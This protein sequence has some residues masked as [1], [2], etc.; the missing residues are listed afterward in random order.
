MTAIEPAALSPHAPDWPHCGQGA[1]PAAASVGCCGRQ[2][3]PYAECLAHLSDANR[4]AYLTSLQPGADV[5]HRGTTFTE[6]LLSQLLT[7][8]RDPATEWPC[9]GHAQFGEAKFSG[10]ARFDQVKI[11]GDAGFDRVEIRHT[12]G[13]NRAVIDG[14]AH[15]NRAKIGAHALFDR[16][17]IGGHA[18]F[19]LAEI[20]LT[21]EF[22]RA[23][24]SGNTRLDRVK[25]GGDTKFD[26]VQIGGFVNFED[27]EIGGSIRFDRAKIRSTAE[28]DRIKI[29]GSARFSAAEIGA[30][31]RFNGAEIGDTA[32]FDHV[33]ID[34]D[35]GF[36]GMNVRGHAMFRQAKIGRTAG[37]SRVK[38]DG[39]AEYDKV[40]IGGRALFSRTEIGGH[41]IF[42]RAEIGRTAHFGRVKIR[43]DAKFDGMNIR[44]DANFRTAVF[45]QA[46]AIGPL[47]CTGTLD[48]S[49]TAFGTAVTIEAATSALH[50]RRTR[51]A[52]T[53]AL[54]LRYAAVDLSDAVVEYPLSIAAYSRPFIVDGA[55]MPEAGLTATS[56][57]ARS[58]RG[59][60]A[61]HLV[62]T[63]V[64][65]S[66]CLFAGTIHL[67]QL[68]LEG[69]CSL[70]AVPSALRWRSWWVRWT[71]RRT[72]AEEQHWRAS[73]RSTAD[74]WTPAP[75]GVEAL[76]PASLAPVYRQLRKAFEDGKDEPGAADFYYGE[77]EMRRHDRDT[78]RA[79]RGLLTGYWALSGY[80]LRASR[81]LGWLV[82]AMTATVLVMMLWG[83]P[84]GDPQPESAGT[85]TGHRISLT[86]D[87]PDPVNPDTPLAQRMT[88][89]RFEKALRVVIN[90]VVF[91]S[92]GQ[93]LTTFGTYAEMVSR[94]TEPVLLGLAVLAVRSRVKR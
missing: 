14:D 27:A 90:S 79:E 32:G 48:L 68:R 4:S 44:G 28:F 52:S 86:T 2:V 6:E 91:R 46:A 5:D 83:L 15:F 55:E 45:E 54:R 12:A 18:S 89:Q 20:G 17:V 87:T 59:V 61:A 51:W 62:L 26:R 50:C 67:D 85:L 56:V 38:I 82:L 94:L 35:A 7:A 36:H 39:D 80:G 22:G 71:P 40:K 84:K 31:A 92:S 11:Y 70:A 72:L 93:D 41:A 57:R 81:A 47:V 75:E 88:S 25:I 65:L 58:L 66:E 43:G 30:D 19:S 21:A 77:M 23:E 3:E 24:I 73:R 69:R 76:G 63:D 9:L 49:E 64:D 10:D 8:L 42:R 1:I 78:P 13:F 16:V 29:E 34:N 60:D 33:K 53:A 37:F 74:G